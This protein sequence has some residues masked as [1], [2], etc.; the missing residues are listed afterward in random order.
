MEKPETLM[1]K[2]V[3]LRDMPTIKLL[4]LHGGDPKVDV[5]RDDENVVKNFIDKVYAIREQLVS[6]NNVSL[7]TAEHRAARYRNLAKILE[8]QSEGEIDLYKKYYLDQAA[9]YLEK[10]DDCL[11]IR[12]AVLPSERIE[13][14]KT[15]LAKKTI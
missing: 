15:L 13:E 2:V 11:G 6:L 4:I 7:S 8:A 10:A 14:N 12:S 1:Q 5:G 3:N 9:D